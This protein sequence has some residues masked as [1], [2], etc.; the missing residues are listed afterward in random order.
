[1]NVRTLGLLVYFWDGAVRLR[2]SPSSARRAQRG[3]SRRQGRGGRRRGRESKSCP[4][5]EARERSD[6]NRPRSRSATAITKRQRALSIARKQ[7]Q[8]WRWPWPRKP[9]PRVMPAKPASRSVNCAGRSAS[10][11][12][13]QAIRRWFCVRIARAELCAACGE[14]ERAAHGLR[15]GRRA[16]GAARRARRVRRG[17]QGSRGG[18][19]AR[20][21]RYGQAILGRRAAQLRQRRSEPSDQG[22]GVRG[23]A[24][25]RDRRRR[26]WS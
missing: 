19:R 14:S 9:R 6:R 23:S 18:S 12:S 25:S 22:L 4:T 10:D 5:R 16:T 20:P 2:R 3:A 13:V 17:G 7:M 8:S 1:M 11:A 21:A 24:P 15:H 26:R